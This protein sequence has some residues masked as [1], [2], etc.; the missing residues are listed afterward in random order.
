MWGYVL[1]RS[2]QYI[3]VL[4][5]A[6]LIN[7]ALPR[8]APG[9]VVDF[10]VPPDSANLSVEQR[11]AILESYDLGGSVVSQFW[12]Y[13]SG[14]PRGEFGLSVIY[15]RPVRDLLLERLPWTLLLVGGA[16]VLA[17]V[18][19]T[20]VGFRSGWH[21]GSRRD[22][23]LL[24]GVMMLSSMP[25]FF[26]ALLLI[27]AFSINLGWFPVYGATGSSGAVGFASIA[28]V[29]QRVVL[30]MLS[31]TLVSLGA[32]YLVARPSIVSESREDYVL[33]A[34]AK[35]LGE[36]DVRRH[37]Q[38]NA[39]IPVATIAL[40]G[41]GDLVG[42]ATVIETVF[43]YPGV[44]RL[45]Y[46]SVL[47]RDYPVLQGAFFLLAVTVIVANLIADLMYP[48]LDPRVRQSRSTATS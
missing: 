26:V 32:V 21:R 16:T 1:R 40:I 14:I 45:I 12:H 15:G 30:P 43:A 13:L 36:R 2:G 3:L 22:V 4:L 27:L 34:R 37:A 8:L 42:G 18:I 35:G 28:D 6:I 9:N 11:E 23:G 47:R 41:L 48:F 29:A 25:A 38:R 7:F 24:G 10:L 17:V 46:D 19:G 31:L 20:L 33:M 5:G 44:G 39:M